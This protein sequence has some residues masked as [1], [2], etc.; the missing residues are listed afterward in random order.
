[1]TSPPDLPDLTPPWV[2]DEV[3]AAQAF[4]DREWSAHVHDTEHVH[5]PD[6]RV[7]PDVILYNSLGDVVIA[8][9]ECS[10][11]RI[12]AHTDSLKEWYDQRPPTCECADCGPAV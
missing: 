11:C 9:I 12:A 10:Y 2:R 8:N 3:A 5:R 6:W 4:I 7:G 1:M